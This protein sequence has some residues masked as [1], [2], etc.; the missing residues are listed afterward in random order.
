MCLII[1]PDPCELNSCRLTSDNPA[2]TYLFNE[3]KG[4]KGQRVARLNSLLG[5]ALVEAV[6]T[7]GAG[8]GRGGGGGGSFLLK[9]AE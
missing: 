9:L 8:R 6:G 1:S 5:I 3:R 4:Y 7:A 2:D